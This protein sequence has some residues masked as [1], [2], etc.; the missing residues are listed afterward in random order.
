MMIILT[1]S[2]ILALA[3]S[4]EQSYFVQITGDYLGQQKGEEFL[5]LTVREFIWNV[6]AAGASPSTVPSWTLHLPAIAYA[7]GSSV[8]LIGSYA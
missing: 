5:S 6:A 7:S 8:V 2:R 3:T 1:V 4:L